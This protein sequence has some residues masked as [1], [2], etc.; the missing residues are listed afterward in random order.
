MLK[1]ISQ[2]M[3]RYGV[4]LQSLVA[5]L[6]SLFFSQ[7]LLFPPCTLC[8]YQRIALYPI[9]LLSAIGIIRKDN[10]VYQYILPLSLIGLV[11][12]LYHNFLYLKLTPAAVDF[13]NS[14]VSCTTHYIQW[15]GFI[16]IPFLALLAFIVINV[17]M[18]ISWRKDKLSNQ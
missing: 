10:K 16:T 5:M 14:G 17:L 13:C 3:L 8:W 1:S 9:V 18:I 12:S 15:F 6:G 4:F 7:V 11:I 2:E